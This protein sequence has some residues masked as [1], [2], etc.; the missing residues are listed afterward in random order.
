MKT[1]YRAVCFGHKET[2]DLFVNNP[3]TTAHY[4]A[5]KDQAIQDWLSKHYGCQ[6]ELV[7]DFDG[8]RVWNAGCW[9]PIRK[10]PPSASPERKGK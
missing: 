9:D 8:D 2:I 4:L 5:D 3:T 1:W 7:G 6:L 10:L